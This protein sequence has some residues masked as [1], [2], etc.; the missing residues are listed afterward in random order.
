MRISRTTVTYSGSGRLLK[1]FRIITFSHY[2]EP[3]VHL[4]DQLNISIFKKIVI[5]RIV[6]QMFKQQ[7]GRV[8]VLIDNIFAINDEYHNCN[9]RQSKNLHTQ[10]GNQELVYNLFSFHGINIWN[11]LSHKNS[12]DVSYA[13]FK[14]LVKKYLQFYDIPYRVY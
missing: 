8:P 6:L 1:I 14:N 3:S 2:L 11:H 4:F 9:T 7:T 13:C 12:S 5:Q 10:I